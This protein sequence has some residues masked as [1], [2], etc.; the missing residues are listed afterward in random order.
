MTDPMTMRPSAIHTDK[1]IASCGCL[2]FIC[3]PTSGT[4]SKTWIF[5]EA[6]G[7]ASQGLAA[8]ERP[9]NYQSLGTAKSDYLSRGVSCWGTTISLNPQAVVSL[10]AVSNSGRSV[11]H[12]YLYRV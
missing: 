2:R 7:V 10:S 8:S 4:A 6:S 1:G 11:P 12:S 9:A 5:G 3:S